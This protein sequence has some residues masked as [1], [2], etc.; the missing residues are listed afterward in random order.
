[1]LHINSVP[2]N[3][4]TFLA[5]C[6]NDNCSAVQNGVNSVVKINYLLRC[7]SCGESITISNYEYQKQAYLRSLK[8]ND[9][10]F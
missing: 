8:K 7:L 4:D 6:A 3:A 5:A 2:N 1:M 10:A 9:F